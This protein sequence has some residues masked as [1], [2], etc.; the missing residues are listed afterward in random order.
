MLGWT[1]MLLALARLAVGASAASCNA[2]GC[3]D[4]AGWAELLTSAAGEPSAAVP[5]LPAKKVAA[6]PAPTFS[7]RAAGAKRLSGAGDSS[8]LWPPSATG[9]V[10]FGVALMV[11]CV[12]CVAAA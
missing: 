7:Q 11:A 2:P 1:R 6:L 10:C 12:S 4:E 9:A 8:L 5:S 3:G